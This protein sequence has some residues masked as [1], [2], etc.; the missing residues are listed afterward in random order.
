MIYVQSGAVSNIVD[1][2]SSSAV[3]VLHVELRENRRHNRYSTDEKDRQEGRQ[4]ERERE[5]ERERK[6]EY[7]RVETQWR[8]K[9][10]NGEGIK[11]FFFV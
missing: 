3:G 5:R 11:E 6:R 1:D 9:G 10:E 7:L 4:E 2:T 8:K